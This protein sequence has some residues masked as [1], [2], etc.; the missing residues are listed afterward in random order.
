MIA[1]IIVDLVILA[2]IIVGAIL[3][4]KYGFFLAVTKP[5]RWFAA[6]ILAFVLCGFVS[7]VLIQPLIE[8]PMTVQITEYLTEKC[9][10]L[11]AETAEKELPTVL[12]LAG[13]MVGV[14]YESFTGENA[15]EFIGQIVDKLAL[16]TISLISTV[17]SFF[18]LYFV[19]KILLALSISILNR[20]FKSGV[21]GVF[22][23]ILG[24]VFGVSFAFVVAWL[25][26]VLFGYITSIPIFASAD[27]IKEFDGGYLYGFFKRM[28]PLDLLFS[29]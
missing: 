6:L 18:L 7:D 15:E 3:G 17:L 14:D 24:F 10:D 5:V 12:K 19:L 27:W 25:G 23:K 26:V 22:N 2:I 13:L 21:L 16:P 8:D 4:I 1:A 20:L 29:F 11:T 28:S 9:P